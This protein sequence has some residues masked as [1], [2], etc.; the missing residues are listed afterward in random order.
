MEFQAV[1]TAFERALQQSSTDLTA[2]LL[3]LATLDGLRGVA[4]FRRASD[5]HAVLTH[6]IGAILTDEAMPARCVVTTSRTAPLRPDAAGRFYVPIG[7]IEGLHG[8]LVLHPDRVEQGPSEAVGRYLGTVLGLLVDR[9]TLA[10]AQR[11]LHPWIA[12]WLAGSA[13]IF[14]ASSEQALIE[15]ACARIQAGGLVG[16]SRVVPLRDL[17]ESAPPSARVMR[18]PVW[19]RGQPWGV[20]DFELPEGRRDDRAAEELFALMSRLLGEVLDAWEHVQ[21]LRQE[22]DRQRYWAEHDSVTGLLNRA[23]FVRHLTA[24]LPEAGVSGQALGVVLVDLDDFK[25]VNDTFGHAVGDA[26]LKAFG[27]RLTAQGG[28]SDRVARLGGDEFGV[29][30][31]GQG[32]D[33]LTDQIDHLADVLAAP[34]VVPVGDAATTTVVVGASYGLT[35]YPADRGDAEQLIRHADWACYHAKERKAGREHPWSLYQALPPDGSRYAAWIPDGVRV[36]Y[37]PIVEVQTGRV[38]SLEAL[39]RLADGDRLLAPAAFLPQLSA[40][41]LEQMTYR[42]MDLVLQ[43]MRTLDRTWQSETP[44]A[45]SVNLEPSMLSP[46]CIRHIAQQVAASAVDPRRITLELLETSDFLSQALAKHQLQILKEK[47]FQLAL[48]DVGSAYSSLLRIKELPI[49]TLKLDQAF[50]RTIPDNPDDLLFVIS[51]QTLAR[52]FRAQF[53]AEGVETPD[54]LDALQVLGV[55]RVQG[56]GVAPPLSLTDLIAWGRQY[57]ARPATGRPHTLLGAYAAHLGFLFVQR[58]G[59]SP[60]YDRRGCPMGRFLHH[61]EGVDPHVITL[62]HLSHQSRTAED[63]ATALRDAVRRATPGPPGLARRMLQV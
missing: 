21:S 60:P 50:V 3:S 25:P 7:G 13:S 30:L 51:V 36:H 40:A 14:A 20:W 23:G 39:V 57:P 2:A 53:V 28:G 16:T 52:G 49:D 27:A 18:V 11:A 29:L 61:A 42:I 46:G 24:A 9:E 45:I 4:F 10:R 22:A 37:Q 38:H 33:D 58:A 55:D 48:D 59:E 35:R 43:D 44:L 63:S 17:A 34:Y 41:E 62:H 47:H 8:W 1:Q 26:L 6:T 5:G 19:R 12:T 54:I 15:E 32:D 31:W 56:Y